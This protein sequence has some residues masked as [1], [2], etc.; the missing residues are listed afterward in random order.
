MTDA[1]SPTTNTPGASTTF[2]NGSTSARPARSV[3]VPSIFGIGDAATPSVQSTVALGILLP[4][5]ITPLSSTVSTLQLIG[6]HQG[7]PGDHSWEA[8]SEDLATQQL[9]QLLAISAA[10]RRA[11]G[12]GRRSS[13][14]APKAFEPVRLMQRRIRGIIYPA[15]TPAP[16]RLFRVLPARPSLKTDLCYAEVGVPPQVPVAR[17]IVGG[18]AALLIDRDYHLR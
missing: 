2:R 17:I 7:S 10:M 14:M 3:L 12:I 9:R 15:D 1:A 6:C 8:W 16:Q 5:A 13:L 11:A 4:P 18:A